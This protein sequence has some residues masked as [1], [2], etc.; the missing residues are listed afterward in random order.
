MTVAEHESEFKLI[1]DTPYLA[2]TGEL[3][4]VYYENFGEIN[5]LRPSDTYMRQYTSHHWFR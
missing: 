5:L 4:G 3:W 2:V 1:A